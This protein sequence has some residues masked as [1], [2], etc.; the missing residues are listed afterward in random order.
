LLALLEERGLRAPETWWNYL[1][2]AEIADAQFFT[3]IAAA[4]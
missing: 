1:W 3:A 2:T 4:A